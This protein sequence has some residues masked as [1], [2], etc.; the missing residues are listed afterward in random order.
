MRRLQHFRLS[1]MLSKPSTNPTI[2][3]LVTQAAPYRV[4]GRNMLV[5]REGRFGNR[6]IL[7]NS[8]RMPVVAWEETFHET[9]DSV[10]L[11]WQ[12]F[13]ECAQNIGDS[14]RTAQ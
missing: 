7:P 13:W 8:G 2:M 5:G 11:D 10:T 9:W 4:V 12:T 3:R 6:V 1:P 14:K